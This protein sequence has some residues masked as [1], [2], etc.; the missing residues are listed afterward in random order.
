[1]LEE[2]EA[3]DEDNS[4]D[5]DEGT[6]TS[7]EGIN[8]PKEDTERDNNASEWDDDVNQD[9]IRGGGGSEAYEWESI[10]SDE[11]ED[12]ESLEVEEIE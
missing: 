10:R 12:E 2:E 6:T 5:D 3:R 1:M 9:A 4:E 11:D 7:G 8:G